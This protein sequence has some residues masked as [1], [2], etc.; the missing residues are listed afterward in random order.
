MS[1]VI[2]CPKCSQDIHYEQY[3][4]HD[5]TRFKTTPPVSDERAAGV[6]WVIE[7]LSS[8]VTLLRYIENGRIIYKVSDIEDLPSWLEQQAKEQGIL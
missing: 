7:Q 8:R 1:G 4:F 6:K 3:V 5:C 2:K